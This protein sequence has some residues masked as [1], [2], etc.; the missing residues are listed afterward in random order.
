MDELKIFICG[1]FG[2]KKNIQIGGQHA[3]TRQLKDAIIS[4]LGEENVSYIDTAD[5]MS[6]PLT[7][8][9]KIKKNFIK[10]HSAIILPGKNRLKFFLPIFTILK[11]KFN[12][13][14]RYVVI[15]GWLSKFLQKN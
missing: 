5:I 3:K 8:L 7:F 9:G 2:Y 10:N 14:L 11:N 4:K 1:N 15:G 13:D 6:N 12:T